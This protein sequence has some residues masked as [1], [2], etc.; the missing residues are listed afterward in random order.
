[1]LASV[2]VIVSVPIDIWVELWDVIVI[3]DD[4]VG[5]SVTVDGIS[6]SLTMTVSVLTKW[7]YENEEKKNIIIFCF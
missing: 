5:V 7:K 3:V 4:I 2:F 6:V 1:M